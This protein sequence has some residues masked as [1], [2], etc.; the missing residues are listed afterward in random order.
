M[1]GGYAY[2]YGFA[3]VGRWGVSGLRMCCLLYVSVLSILHLP[4]ECMALFQE[5]TLETRSWTNRDRGTWSE[6][7]SLIFL[8]EAALGLI[9]FSLPHTS[10]HMFGHHPATVRLARRKRYARLESSE[11]LAEKPA[12]A[13]TALELHTCCASLQG[14]TCRGAP[15]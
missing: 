11:A 7:S 10:S 1:L 3:R 4:L 15:P 5:K 9:L 8:R 2:P 13:R 6:I 12:V 14:V